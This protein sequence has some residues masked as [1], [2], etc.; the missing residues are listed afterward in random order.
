MSAQP[1]R[2]DLR[3][4]PGLPALLGLQGLPARREAKAIPAPRVR[5]VCL[6]TGI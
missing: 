6:G 5:R 3:A 1:D 4:I 2:L